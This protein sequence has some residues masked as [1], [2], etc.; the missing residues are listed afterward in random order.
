MNTYK[1]NPC[2]KCCDRTGTCHCTCDR[3]KSWSKE[4]KKT[5]D[6][7]HLKKNTRVDLK[8]SKSQGRKR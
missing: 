7:I 2:Y 5:R 8:L 4:H 3:Y 6:A 1:N